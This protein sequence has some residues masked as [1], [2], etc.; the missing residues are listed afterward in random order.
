MYDIDPAE[1]HRVYPST[2]S[3]VNERE[4]RVATEQTAEV[5]RLKATVEGLERLCRQIEN[6]R[7]RLFHQLEGERDSLREQNIR[8]TALLTDQRAKP[9]SEAI[10]MPPPAS[11]ASVEAQP[12]SPA[13]V[14]PTPA[15]NAQGSVP[16]AHGGV[17]KAEAGWFRRMMGGR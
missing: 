15:R 5:E 11:P 8:L 14:P 2:K 17:P 9:A 1:L 3:E 6:D 13:H 10:P 12:A 7:D 16:E 4:H